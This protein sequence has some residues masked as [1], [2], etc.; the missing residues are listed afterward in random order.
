M[1]SLKLILLSTILLY[2][3]GAY[4]QT[5]VELH[6]THKLSGNTPFSFNQQTKN[7][8]GNDLEFTRVE[9]YISKISI[10]HDGGMITQVPNHYILVNAQQ[11]VTDQLGNFN[12]T[13][14]ESIS[15]FIGVDTPA[16]NADPSAQPSGHPL[17]PK[18]P[19]MHWGWASGYRFIAIEGNG[20]ASLNQKFELHGLFNENYYEQT[21]NV[22]GVSK[23]GKLIIALNANY[24]QCL[25]GIDVSAGLISHG[26]N[27]ADKTAL[28]NFRDN[29]FKSGNPVSVKNV[30]EETNSLVIY[31]NPT[32]GSFNITS[33]Q[34]NSAT[35][36]VLD[37]QGRIIK[38]LEKSNTQ[39]NVK[40]DIQTPGV[41]ILKAAFDS[42]NTQ[43]EKIVVQ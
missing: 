25:K 16:N 32:T 33:N 11:D 26:L 42:G 7:D 22:S 1:K 40:I 23:N 9:Y 2:S 37:I 31:P 19:S 20:G 24:A 34:A 12:I 3:L 18:S 10:K 15:F 8:L 17:A 13:N 35:I 6:I 30:T 29:V 27:V 38:Q 4:A 21:I 5:P 43:V 14:V 41:Y 36:S 28:A 39:E